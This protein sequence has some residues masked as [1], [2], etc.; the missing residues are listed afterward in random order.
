MMRKDRVMKGGMHYFWKMIVY[1]T[2]SPYAQHLQICL[3]LTS[4]HLSV[5]E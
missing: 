1:R 3:T 5:T 4:A 2:H